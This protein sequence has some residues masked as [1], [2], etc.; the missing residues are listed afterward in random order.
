MNEDSSIRIINKA[1]D[2]MILLKLG[3]YGVTIFKQTQDGFIVKEVKECKKN[4][5]N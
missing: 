1:G 3:E 2:S 4:Y 5:K